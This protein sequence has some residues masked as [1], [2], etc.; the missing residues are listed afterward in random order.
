MEQHF[1]LDS[2]VVIDF[3]A[4]KLPEEGKK[5]LRGVVNAVPVV[6][7]ITR[8]EV[9]GFSLDAAASKLL[10]DFMEASVVIDLSL[11]IADRTIALRRSS[12]LKTPDAIIAAT[13][14]EYQLVL[15]TRNTKDFATVDGLQLVNPWIISH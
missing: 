8:I 13:A 2:N 1:L 6:S 11:G 5:L 3:L 14:L 7:V 4:G 10:N 9:L 15:L 12:R